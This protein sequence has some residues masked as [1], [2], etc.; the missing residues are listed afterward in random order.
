MHPT[1]HSD[2]SP[3]VGV[4]VVSYNS[5]EWLHRCLSSVPEASQRHESSVIVIDNASED[6]SADLVASEFPG[7]QLIRSLDNLGFARAVNRAAKS[8]ETDYLLLLNPDGYLQRNAIDELVDFAEANPVYTICGGRTLTPTGDLDPRSC[9]A[10]P[11]LWSVAANAVMLSAVFRR[12]RVFSPEAMVGYQRDHIRP[13]DIVTGC[14]LLIRTADWRELGGFD[15][16]YFVYG[17]DADLCLRARERGRR[18]AITPDA[19]MVHAGGES[20]ESTPL[21]HELVFAGRITLLQ[22]QWPPAKA[23]IG[24]ALVV[25]SVLFRAL[26]ASLTGR[27]ESLLWREVWRRR[28]NWWA[29]HRAPAPHRTHEDSI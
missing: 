22:A 2:R 15:E 29:G 24:Q 17:E 9:W 8:L 7:V 1:V 11:T 5:A 4:V 28:Q 14:L 12:S 23:R 25:A 21:H 20:A 26:F 19:V 13:V 18:C 27:Q 10:A 3:T 16:R 6:G